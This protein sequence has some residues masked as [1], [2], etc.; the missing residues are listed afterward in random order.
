MKRNTLVSLLVVFAV[1]AA[2]GAAA[3][4]TLTGQHSRVT[5][6]SDAPVTFLSS[7]DEQSIDTTSGSESVND[8]IDVQNDNGELQMEIIFIEN[9]EDNPLDD[10]NHS[11]DVDITVSYDGSPITSGDIVTLPSSST[12]RIDIDYGIVAFACPQMA[13]VNLTASVFE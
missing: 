8:Y 2:T 1:M 4:L 11:G 3:W 5:I 7:M 6:T 10:C 12:K 13:E 9:V